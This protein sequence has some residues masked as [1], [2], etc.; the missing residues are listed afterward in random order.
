V[1]PE[2]AELISR[3]NNNN[4]LSVALRGKTGIYPNGASIEEQGEQ[5]WE[6]L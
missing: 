2:K 6:K 1:C 3:N 4:N 5:L